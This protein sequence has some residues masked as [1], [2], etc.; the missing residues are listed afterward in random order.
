MI[1]EISF[2]INNVQ[3]MDIC[4]NNSNLN[5]KRKII[6]TILIKKKE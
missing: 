4:A 2:I 5:Q 6:N 3:Y 1:S